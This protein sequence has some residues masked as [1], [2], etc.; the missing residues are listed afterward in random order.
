MKFNYLMKGIPFLSTLL[1]IIF[2]CISNQKVN[3]KLK[4]LIWNTPSLT[5]GNYIAISTA[6]GFIFSYII[7]NNIAKAYQTR[8]K[9]SLR[10]KK[11]DNYE[12]TYDNIETNTNIGYDNTLIERNIKDPSP[13][14]DASFRIIGRKDGSYKNYTKKNSEYDASIELDEQYDKRYEDSETFNNLKSIS[15]DWNDE[16]YSRW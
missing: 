6:S 12:E 5:L 4:I 1:I 16:S 14:I 10:Y 2:L 3:T 15:N 13:T 8:A 11:Y 9:E 7:T